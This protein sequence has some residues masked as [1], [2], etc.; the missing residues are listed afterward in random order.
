MIGSAFAIS[1]CL[2]YYFGS[3]LIQHGSATFSAMTSAMTTPISIIMWYSIPAMTKWGCGSKFSSLQ[4]I[5]GSIAIPFMAIGAFIFQYF[6]R[7]E[8]TQLQEIQTENSED[9]SGQASINNQD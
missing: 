3:Y 2:S 7:K 9:D 1:Y 6:E 8:Q 4:I 5:M